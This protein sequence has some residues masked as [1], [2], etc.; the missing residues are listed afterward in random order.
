MTM[1]H[2]RSRSTRTDS[3][4]PTAPVLGSDRA[5]ALGRSATILALTMM[6]L[7]L[8][9]TV[10]GLLVDGVYT[11]DAATAAMLRGYDLVTL[12]IA[13]PLLLLGLV[14]ARRGTLLGLVLT[15]SLLAYTGYT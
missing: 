9:A 5:P 6:V 8:G 13:L 7:V 10:A 15:A 3:Q 2:A 4:L 1:T 14:G 11:T 12:V